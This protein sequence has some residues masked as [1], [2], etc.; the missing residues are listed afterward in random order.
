MT[1]A[2]DTLCILFVYLLF[3][4]AIMYT[5]L[6]AALFVNECGKHLSVGPKKIIA[7]M[8]GMTQPTLYSD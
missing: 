6:V 4:T 8:T 3:K 5:H 1:N 2:V 7:C